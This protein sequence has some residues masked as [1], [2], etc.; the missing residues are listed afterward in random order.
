VPA[1]SSSIV[2]TP[3]HKPGRDDGAREQQQLQPWAS[4]VGPA[5]APGLYNTSRVGNITLQRNTVSGASPT[6]P[7]APWPG[8][9][10]SERNVNASAA[11]SARVLVGPYPD[12]VDVLQWGRKGL[13]MPATVTAVAAGNGGA[14]IGTTGTVR[15][16]S[17]G[18][19]GKC[20]WV[21]CL[22]APRARLEVGGLQAA[23]GSGCQ[24]G[25]T[26]TRREYLLKARPADGRVT[27]GA[28]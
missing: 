23:V 20:T 25:C 9:V 26:G 12:L 2:T 22:L 6:Y 8:N 4:V 21:S 1:L 13:G 14:E 10:T 18:A 15:S 5:G 19:G 24:G 7:R 28:L 27:S 16:A 3:V 11:A 17:D